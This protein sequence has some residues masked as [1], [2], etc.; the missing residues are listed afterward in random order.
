[1]QLYHRVFKRNRSPRGDA[2]NSRHSKH[3]ATPTLVL[4]QRVALLVHA[5]G[6]NSPHR[7]NRNGVA[8]ELLGHRDWVDAH[9]KDDA[10][11]ARLP[12]PLNGAVV[13]AEARREQFGCT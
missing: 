1:M 3:G 5:V 4:Q 8:H 10:A 12:K 9:V 11:A 2:G 6:A 7:L 13:A